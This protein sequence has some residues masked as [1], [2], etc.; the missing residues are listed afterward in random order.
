MIS[1]IRVP[2]TFVLIF[3]I[4]ILIAILTWIIPAGECQRIEKDGRSIIIP[5][6]FKKI[7]SNPQGLGDLLKAPV[8]GFIEAANIIM[9]ILFIGGVFGIFQATG[10]IDQFLKKI[11]LA[12][13][14]SKFLQKALIPIMVIIFSL[15]GAIF[16]M[17]EEVIPFVF[18]FI[19]LAISLG[20][21]SIVG[22]SIPFLG[23]GLGFAGAILNP[24]TIGVAQGISELPLYS[25]LI[26]RLIVWIIVTFTGVVWIVRYANKV[27]KNPEFS[28]VYEIDKGRKIQPVEDVLNSD[29]TLNSAH[30]AVL[31]V[32]V[33]TIF[34]LIFGVY[35]YQWY[36][37]E[38]AALFLASGII[39]GLIGKIGLNRIAENFIDGAKSI[40][41]AA[42]IVAFARGILIVAE[43]GRIIDT[44]LS[45]LSNSISVVHPVISA[46]IMV[47][48]QT[49][50]NF[51]VPSGSGQAAFTI[52]VMS[53]L[54]DLVGIT[55]QTAVLAFQFGDGFTNMIIPTSAVTMGVLSV[56]KIPWE[57]WAW[58]LIKLE[59]ILF[60]LSF[61]LII[62]PVL[63]NWG[64]F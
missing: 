29:V 57:K 32:F 3:S 19:P 49:C 40:A 21:D 17:S 4:T 51:F 45:S 60:I 48:I 8:E 15:F 20:Y 28:P 46:Q 47:V 35:R 36:I 24:F 6:S 61:L 10:T 50:I 42:L 37:N 63:F 9:F 13:Y 23:A 2:N 64:P 59:I 5:D 53:A 14:R 22:I 52:P 55:R 62:P 25:G 30:K 43:N 54:S 39:A 44:I 12:H 31:G 56:A 58:W 34:L 18:I 16:G 41:G 26:Y 33:L 7:D 27:K 38:I 1:R 11:I